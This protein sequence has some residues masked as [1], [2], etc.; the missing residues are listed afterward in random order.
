MHIAVDPVDNRFRQRPIDIFCGDRALAV[1]DEPVGDARMTVVNGVDAAC[2]D[3]GEG[4]VEC[5]CLPGE[6]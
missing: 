2:E 1:D 4:L 3:C 6:G 5:R